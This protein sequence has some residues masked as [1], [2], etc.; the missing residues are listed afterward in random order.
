MMKKYLLIRTDGYSIIVKELFS[1]KDAYEAMKK[2]Y[3]EFY[4]PNASE[5]SIEMSHLYNEDAI[6]YTDNDVYVWKIHTVS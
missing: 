6:L 5:S 3:Y 1:H 2:E 4:N